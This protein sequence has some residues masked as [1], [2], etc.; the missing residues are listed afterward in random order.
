MTNQ[1]TRVLG[2]VRLTRRSALGKCMA[3]GRDVRDGDDR[4]RLP[5]GGFAHRGCSTYR[6]RHHA[7]VAR[8]LR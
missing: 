3:C 1:V 8:R 2:M 4:L 5:G 7:R 6:M